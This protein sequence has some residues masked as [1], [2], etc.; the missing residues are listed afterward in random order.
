MKPKE[1]QNLLLRYTAVLILIGAVLYLTHNYIHLHF[2]EQETYN[3]VW[4]VY[5]F[6]TCL[7]LVAIGLISLGYFISA[8]FTGYAFVGVVLLKMFASLVFLY[9]LL[10]SNTEDKIL[11]VVYFFV[12]FF[13]FLFLEVW[14]SVQLLTSKKMN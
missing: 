5:A 9:P 2:V 13:V 14:F 8:D 1:I 3:P 7:S 11:D 12:P 4:K 6:L 10:K